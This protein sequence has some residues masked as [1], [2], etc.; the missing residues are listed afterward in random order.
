[1]TEDA[2]DRLRAHIRATLD[3]EPG[4]D[5]ATSLRRLCVAIVE[6]LGLRTATVLMSTGSASE[7]VAATSDEAD[8]HL[9]ELQFSLGEGP[10]IEA[11]DAARPVLASDLVAEQ[12]RWPGYAPEALS[13]GAGAVYAFPLQVGAVRLGVL[14]L[15]SSQP[16]SLSTLEASQ[17]LVFAEVATERLLE[18]T[19]DVHDGVQPE[20]EIP[21]KIRD[22]VFQAQGMIMVALGV[23]LAHALARLRAHAFAESRDLDAV[24]ADVV[25]GRLELPQDETME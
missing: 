10:G 14:M 7:G 4:P 21:L 20:V 24:A 16:R 22:V 5:V 9:G 1:M 3:G 8:R 12:S 25:A 2:G 6:E 11:F 23:D 13:A 15:Y 17:C 19:G 18:A